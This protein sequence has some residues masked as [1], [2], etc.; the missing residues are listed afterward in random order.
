[1]PVTEEAVYAVLKDC[2]DP[3]IPVNI[4]DL[5]LVYGVDI[6]GEEV[7]VTMTLTSPGC[8]SGPYIG[9]QIRHKLLGLEGV[10]QARVEFVW[11]PAWGPERMSP[12]AKAEL[13]MDD[14]WDDD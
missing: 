7:H 6:D 2:Y 4:V 10:K 14:D 9:E 3:E 11:E 5:G 13:G 12:E 1:M 8:P